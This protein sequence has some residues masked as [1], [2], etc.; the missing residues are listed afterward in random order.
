MTGYLDALPHN[1]G[2]VGGPGISSY[3]ASLNQAAAEYVA[4]AAPPPTPQSQAPA[5]AAPVES[6]ASVGGSSAPTS[7]S[8]LAALSTGSSIGGP[9]IA[10]Y[11]DV[12]PRSAA[13]AGGAGISTYASNIVSSN[14]AGGPGLTTYTDALSGPSSFAK[15]YAPSGNYS[16]ASGAAASFAM[17]STTG[18]FDLTLEADAETI[19]LLKANAG[20]RVTMTGTITQW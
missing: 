9:G 5:P 20:R 7:G 6:S 13:L 17:G 14:V 8:Y 4:A 11:L 16:P 2:G 18:T 1:S 12:L 15:S 19:E 3:A 10:S